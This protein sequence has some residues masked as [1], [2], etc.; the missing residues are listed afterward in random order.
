MIISRIAAFIAVIILIAVV[1]IA[2]F[3]VT[4][5][6]GA[7]I[8]HGPSVAHAD[9][10]I[11]SMNLNKNFVL[12]EANG[13]QQQFQCVDRCLMAQSHMQRHIR[14]KAHTDI[15]YIRDKA[16]NELLAVDVD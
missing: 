9:G 14:E 6:L 1:S 5:A 10:V 3:D 15:Y 16:N 2:A 4:H 7:E 8:T 11:V 12:K 13:V